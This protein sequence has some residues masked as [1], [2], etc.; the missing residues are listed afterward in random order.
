ME[1]LLKDTYFWKTCSSLRSL[2]E[3][4]NAVPNLQLPCFSSQYT[5][6]EHVSKVTESRNGNLENQQLQMIIGIV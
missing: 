2:R 5:S 4:S 6:L 1:H 3:R